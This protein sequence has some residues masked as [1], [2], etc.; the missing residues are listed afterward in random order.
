MDNFDL[1]I[2]KNYVLHMSSEEKNIFLEKYR[3]NRGW[4]V[5]DENH[6]VQSIYNSGIAETLKDTVIY[7]QGLLN[8]SVR[9]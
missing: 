2:I 4:T 9:K 8:E 5:E 1:S 6:A 7:L 3:K